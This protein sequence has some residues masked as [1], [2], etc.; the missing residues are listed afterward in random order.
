MATENGLGRQRLNGRLSDCTSSVNFYS[1]SP[2]NS[3]PNLDGRLSD[4]TT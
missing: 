2:G 4:S 3:V 1:D